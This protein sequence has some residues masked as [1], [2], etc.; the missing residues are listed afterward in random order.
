MLSHWQE[1]Y[2][3]KPRVLILVDRPG[4]AYDI[5]AQ[6]LRKS[7]S[8]DF[9]IEIAYV[10]D[11]PD[12]HAFAFDIIH[13]CWWGEM[14]HL[15]F[16]QE[17][18]RIVK[19]VSSHRWQ[20][21][22]QYGPISPEQF[23]TSYLADAG[24]VTATSKRLQHLV[25]TVRPCLLTPN[26]FTENIKIRAAATGEL[27]IGWA[28][29]ISDPCKGLDDILLPASEGVCTLQ[30]ASGNIPASEMSQFYSTIDVLCI[31]S[32]YEGE[33]L[34]LLEA[35]AAGCFP[36]ATDV[37][38]VPELVTNGKNGLIV[39]RTPEAFRT[40]L[41]WCLEQPDHVRAMGQENGETIQ[42]VRNW[43]KVKGAW[44]RAW[45]HALALCEEQAAQQKVSP[46]VEM[47][48]QVDTL[49]VSTVFVSEHSKTSNDSDATLIESFKKT[50]GRHYQ[51]CNP[52]ST[53]EGA[54]RS[55]QFYYAAE[56]AFLPERLK[57]APALE[58][59]AGH[60]LLLRFLHEKGFSSL[61]GIDI[62][63]ELA[64]IAAQYLRPYKIPVLNKDAFV[65]LQTQKE[66]FG[67][68]TAFDVIEHF[69]LEDGFTFAKSIHRSLLP[70]GI[71]VFR[72]INMANIF[73][74]YSLYIDLTHQ[75][76]YTERNLVELILQA[77]FSR[78]ELYLPEW[79]PGHPNTE[80]L[81]ESRKVHEYLF[82]LQDRS[83][84]KCFDK[85][86][87]VYGVK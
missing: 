59:G 53:N 28:G 38:I 58:I 77:G 78:A 56:L 85:N 1:K 60:G 37:G 84:A 41:Q 55:A 57:P 3:R 26:G 65:F 66:H 62:D 48:E 63:A 27:A 33:P 39:K 4:W 16:V 44:R 10:A 7:L 19:E 47:P 17:K 54:Y 49:S 5:S 68:V 80:K 51:K 13:V 76:G 32:S 64:S 71:A 82:S 61:M 8:N 22:S 20:E 11:K 45:V 31:A 6:A 81:N 14:F 72:T 42:R 9:S 83:V 35:M 18:H 86:V 40:A 69:P 30:I 67:L 29:N 2:G 50:Y 12:L 23:C 52:G 87:I 46:E 24:V 15:D 34:T 74:C 21:Q 25:E 73:G 43:E 75:M 79:L 70:G 36:V